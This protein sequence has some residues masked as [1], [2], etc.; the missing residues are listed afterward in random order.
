MIREE[1]SKI[2]P[3]LDFT[4]DSLEKNENGKC[5]VLDFKVWK[6]KRE[7]GSTK[8]RHTFYEKKVMSPL[9]FH[10]K[11]TFSWRSKIVTLSEKVTRRL[12]NIDQDHKRR[13]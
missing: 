10:T 5:P 2:M 11:D 6:E 13:T 3:G 1:A 12:R 8:I 4:I 7:D 9:V